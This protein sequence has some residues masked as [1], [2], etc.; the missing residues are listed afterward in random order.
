[1]RR[2]C[3]KQRALAR[4]RAAASNNYPVT[5]QY[6][7]HVGTV[8]VSLEDR[9]STQ[10]PESEQ[11][12]QEGPTIHVSPLVPNHCD[13][14]VSINAFLSTPNVTFKSSGDDRTHKNN[15]TFP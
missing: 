12:V 11:F 3:I 10:L 13:A 8:Q 15:S 1:M 5:A 14:K 7:S 2:R 9:S 6:A 4:A